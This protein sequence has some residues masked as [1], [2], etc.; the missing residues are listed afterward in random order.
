MEPDCLNV[1]IRADSIE[2]VAYP[3][4]IPCVLNFKENVFGYW[5]DYTPF[6]MR[7][8]NNSRSSSTVVPMENTMD[9]WK[10]PFRLGFSSLLLMR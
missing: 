7:N 10:P 5:D 2:A 6:S 3:T 1:T 8:S 4:L 9:E